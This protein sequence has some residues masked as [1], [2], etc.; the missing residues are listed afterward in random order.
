MIIGRWFVKGGRVGWEAKWWSP[1]VAK[2][3][4]SEISMEVMEGGWP[5]APLHKWKVD[6]FTTC[7][8]INQRYSTHLKTWPVSTYL[9]QGFYALDCAWFKRVSLAHHCIHKSLY[10]AL[11]AHMYLISIDQHN[12]GSPPILMRETSP[13]PSQPQIYPPFLTT[14]SKPPSSFPP[15]KHSCLWY[16]CSHKCL[17]VSLW[18]GLIPRC[19]GEFSIRAGY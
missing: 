1:N 14:T 19:T 10:A 16:I 18:C 9:C 2:T 3:S 12:L 13:N 6:Q 4:V 5:S 11:L 7:Q 8:N 15:C 17:F